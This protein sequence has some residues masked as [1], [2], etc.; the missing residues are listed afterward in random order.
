[1]QGVPDEPDQEYWYDAQLG[2]WRQGVSTDD[3]GSSPIPMQ[4]ELVV[5]LTTPRTF[6]FTP[7]MV[8]R[9]TG[10]TVVAS[11]NPSAKVVKASVLV[12]TASGYS[13]TADAPEVRT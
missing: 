12:K 9:L 13:T 4:R 1:V 6:Q 7:T 3:K 2:Y 11:V 5:T 10:Q 8:L